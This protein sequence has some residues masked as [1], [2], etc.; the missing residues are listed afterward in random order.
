MLA[1]AGTPAE[2]VRRMAAEV[3]AI[4]RL[5]DVKARLDGMGT[6]PVGGTPAAFASF[7]DAETAKWGRVIREA[8]VQA[9]G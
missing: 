8:K 3:S 7:L 4:V 6:V 1:P 5:D 2:I 9:D